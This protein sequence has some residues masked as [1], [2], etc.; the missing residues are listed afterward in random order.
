M[1]VGPVIAGLGRPR[2]E[3]MLRRVPFIVIIFVLTIIGVPLGIIWPSIK[4]IRSTSEGIYREYQFLEE[5]NLRG[6]NIRQAKKEYK[7]LE[8]RLSE[9]RSLAIEP[10]DELK[11]ITDIETLAAKYNI[12]E[13]HN[14]DVDNSPLAG[15]YFT[16]PLELTLRGSY[17][18]IIRF[19][20]E[21][22]SMPIIT[23]FTSFDLT[24]AYSTD[25][26]RT[27]TSNRNWKSEARL[28]GLVY[29]HANKK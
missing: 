25:A 15:D 7:E 13:T 28:S 3:I 2:N 17:R 19:T 5:R 27:T 16:V 22:E 29:Q 11:F 4:Q 9:L 1:L 8:P 21:L 26:L 18:D 20:L 24:S 12:T 6:K 23:S 14:L 10:G